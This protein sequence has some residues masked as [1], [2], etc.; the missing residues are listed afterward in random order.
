MGALVAAYLVWLVVHGPQPPQSGWINGWAED[1]FYLAAAV[2]CVVGGLRRRPGSYI[3]IV[4]G[5]ALIFTMTG[6]TILTVYT[7]HGIPP[8]PPTAADVFGLGFIVLCFVG[9][10][11]MARKDRERLNPR[12]LLDGGVA[13]LGAG[14]V[15]A[16][17]VLRVFPTG[18]DSRHWV[19][20]SSS[21]TRLALSSSYSSW[22]VPLL[23]PANGAPA[24]HGSRWRRPSRWLPS[25][26][27]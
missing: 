13:A 12:E 16:A 21:P 25:H 14:A 24:E 10:A 6:N 19:R 3:P 4:F 27:R 22:S 18:K 1:A 11:L 9:I 17:F 26:R 8:P 7:L 23:S 20:L 15:C 2:V 5:L